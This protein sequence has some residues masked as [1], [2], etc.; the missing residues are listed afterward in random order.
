MDV[1]FSFFLIGGLSLG[2]IVGILFGVLAGVALLAVVGIL[3]I[4]K[5]RWGYSLNCIK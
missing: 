4:F 2:D 3:V 5:I 1:S